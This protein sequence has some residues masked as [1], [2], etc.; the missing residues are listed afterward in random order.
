M[1]TTQYK[2]PLGTVVKTRNIELELKMRRYRTRREIW[3]DERLNTGDGGL[4][5]YFL[6]GDWLIA[7]ETE[8][9]EVSQRTPLRAAS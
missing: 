8:A 3:F 2:I 6:H 9:V 7:V 5:S 4:V 1:N